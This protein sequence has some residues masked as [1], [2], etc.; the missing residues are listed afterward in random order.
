MLTAIL[1]TVILLSAILLSAEMLTCFRR[2]SDG[3]L[4]PVAGEPRN[5]KRN[6]TYTDAQSRLAGFTLV[7]LL[8]VIGIIGVLIAI[9]LP[10]L[11]KARAQANRTVCLSNIRQ[12]GTGILMYCNDNDGYFP[13]CAV[14]ET[15]PYEQMASDWVWWQ[16]NRDL[17]GSAI[18]AYL[19]TGEKLKAVL[20]CPSDDPASHG[21]G[22]AIAPGQGPYLYS[23]SMND[24]LAN[25]VRGGPYLT[26]IT[27]WRAPARKIMLTEGWEKYAPPRWDP[28]LPLTK[29]HGTVR[30]RKHFPGN[31]TLFSGAIVGANVS[32]VF[33]DGHADSVD[34]RFAVDPIHG[35]IDAQ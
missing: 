7:E 23:Y 2:R 1:M 4:R 34:Q 29:R 33:L 12:L 26:K 27:K 14:P 13:T 22:I 21:E 5:M 16:A 24:A 35:A 6:M 28:L 25:N 11:S 17:N 18:A 31:L 10:L 3:M 15:L 19:G 32:A 30:F 8:V 9:L 20:R